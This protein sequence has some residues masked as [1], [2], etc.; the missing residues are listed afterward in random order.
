MP[1]ELTCNGCSKV[2]KNVPEKYAGKKVICPRCGERLLVP[3]PASAFP[4]VEPISAPPSEPEGPGV[5]PASPSLKRFKSPLRGLALFSAGCLAGLGIAF[6]FP[7][8]AE[9][10]TT[11][12]K[13]DPIP[14]IAPAKFDSSPPAVIIKA[15]AYERAK[16]L[17]LHFVDPPPKLMAGD[18]TEPEL[19]RVLGIMN[20]K[21]MEIEREIGSWSWEKGSPLVHK[22]MIWSCHKCGKLRQIYFV[23][24]T[25]TTKRPQ[26]PR[27][28]AF[29]VV[30]ATETA[31]EG[32]TYELEELVLDGSIK[33]KGFQMNWELDRLWPMTEYGSL[34][35]FYEFNLPGGAQP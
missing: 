11:A 1:I 10:H 28:H 24:G 25:Y 23:F 15:D 3:S 14:I 17:G 26:Q 21:I 12:P 18:A 22:D 4:Q 34:H 6:L 9:T 13:M 16:K 19:R 5:S 29:G 32:L 33:I 35:D 27:R 7:R 8:A 20:R 2:L 30:V 31:A